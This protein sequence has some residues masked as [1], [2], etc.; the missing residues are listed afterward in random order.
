MFDLDPI[1]PRFEVKRALSSQQVDESHISGGNFCWPFTI[2]PPTESVSSSSSS[3]DSTPGHQSSND[4]S[5][6]G[7]VTF[8]LIVTICRRGRLTRN[9]GSVISILYHGGSLTVCFVFRVKQQIFYVPHPDSSPCWWTSPARISISLPGDAAP[10]STPSMSSWP[11]KELPTVRV[12]GVIF[13]RVNIEVECKVSIAYQTVQSERLSLLLAHSACVSFSY[14][15][16][17][18]LCLPTHNPL[19]VNT[20]QMTLSHSAL[21]SQARTMKPLTYF[22]CHTLL[23]YGCRRSWPS[24]SKQKSSAL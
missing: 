9:V 24:E 5:A 3:A 10:I 15:T 23:M 17:H 22:P 18:H 11:R 21:F 4:H 13:N 14:V 6:G 8:Q 16:V 2:T 20:Q 19:R 12:R 1:I 7:D